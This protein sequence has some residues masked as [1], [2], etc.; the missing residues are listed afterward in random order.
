MA[1]RRATAFSAFS[2]ILVSASV[3]GLAPSAS[4]RCVDEGN[5]NYS[6]SAKNSYI[7][8][9]DPIYKDGPGGRLTVSRTKVKSVSAV[10]TAG[11]EAE[12][13]AVLAKAKVSISASLSMTQSV[14]TKH[15]YTHPIKRNMY[16]NA[17]HVVWSKTV[18]WRKYR[19]YSKAGG[20]CA[21]RTIATG[22]IKYPKN[23]EGFRFW[24]SKN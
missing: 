3:I 20:V 11:A 22:K 2:L 9:K 6:L 1:L 24:H 21:T 8:T 13:G 5:V 23:A 15:E 4:A 14:E 16:G 10:V 17:Q 12:V 18:S 7:P 19:V